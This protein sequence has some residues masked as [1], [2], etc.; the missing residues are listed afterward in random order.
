M[1]TRS[2]SVFDPAASNPAGVAFDTST[3]APAPLAGHRLALTVIRDDLDAARSGLSGADR[4]GDAAKELDKAVGDDR[5]WDPDRSL[6]S[7]EGKAVFDKMK[8]VVEEL[9]AVNSPPAAIAT[10]IDTLVALASDMAQDHI[11]KA[12]AGG[13]DRGVIAEANDKMA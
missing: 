8:R 13:G 10:V 11:D 1:S 9:L 7:A 6:N 3:P 12:V 4:A 2:A 5:H